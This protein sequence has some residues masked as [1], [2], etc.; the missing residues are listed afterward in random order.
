MGYTHEQE[1]PQVERIRSLYVTLESVE[2]SIGP[3]DNLGTKASCSSQEPKGI[4][5]CAKNLK[6][7]VMKLVL[8]VV[9]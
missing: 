2:A 4:L 3:P 9:Y 5:L 8:Y 1:N 7:K 6:I